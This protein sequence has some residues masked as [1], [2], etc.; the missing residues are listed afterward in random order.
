MD[1]SFIVDCGVQ[2]ALM[3]LIDCGVLVEMDRGIGYNGVTLPQGASNEILVEKI[4]DY[5]NASLEEQALKVSEEQISKEM[6]LE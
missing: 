5:V 6:G 2:A 1:S 4:T 3:A